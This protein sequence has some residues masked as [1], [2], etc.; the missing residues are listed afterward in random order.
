MRAY[1]AA[2]Y[3]RNRSRHIARVR[4]DNLRRKTVAAEGLET[5]LRAHPCVDCG[6]TD[7]R[8]LEF[9]HRPDEAKSANVS[10]MVGMGLPW[11]RILVEI[12]KCDVRCAN[13]H[14]IATMTRGGHFRWG[15]RTSPRPG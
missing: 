3:G 12:A 13:C 1:Q 2:H 7:V 4:E 11:G 5:Y 6:T 15:W 9:D 14:R 8:V 10:A